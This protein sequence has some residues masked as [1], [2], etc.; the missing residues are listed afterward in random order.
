MPVSTIRAWVIGL[1]W[2]IVVPGANQLFHFRYPAV[3]ISPVRLQL[4]FSIIF[5][6]SVAKSSPLLKIKLVPLL[7][8][9]PMGNLWA[10]YVPKVSRFGISLNPGPF[11]V[12]E[13]VIITVM[14]G[15]GDEA[16]Y[17]VSLAPLS[18]HPHTDFIQTNIIAVQRVFYNQRPTFACQFLFFF[19]VS[20]VRFIFLV[21][22]LLTKSDQWLLVMST[23]LIGFSIGGL[24]KRI[25]VTPQS[26]IWPANLVMAALLN[27]LHSKETSGTHSCGGVSRGRFFTYVLFGYILY[28]Q[29]FLS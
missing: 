5:V 16:A 12:K 19:F 10:R 18:G 17:A 1:F 3:V 4:F 9:F 28:S 14:S 8:S 20:P 2:T 29:R 7:L 13:H 23:Q 26:M 15:V 27:T 22:F 11:T 6:L 25:L 24:C 21:G